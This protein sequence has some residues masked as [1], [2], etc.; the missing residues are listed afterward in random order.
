MYNKNDYRSKFYKG[1]WEKAWIRNRV[2]YAINK[3]INLFEAMWEGYS[4]K[5]EH[6]PKSIL[7]IEN[8]GYDSVND[9]IL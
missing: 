6:M 2:Q 7:Y 5:M 9:S 8:Y 3:K 4:E 1:R